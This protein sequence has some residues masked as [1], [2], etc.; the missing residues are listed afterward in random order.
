MNYFDGDALFSAY[1]SDT[2]NKVSFT[3]HLHDEAPPIVSKVAYMRG[4]GYSFYASDAH[5]EDRNHICRQSVGCP[6]TER[7]SFD[8]NSFHY[9]FGRIGRLPKYNIHWRIGG[10][11]PAQSSQMVR[12]T[13]D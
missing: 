9:D 13:F 3:S 2:L 4:L 5:L 8:I 12:F 6:H 11:C 7:Y 1:L 10:S